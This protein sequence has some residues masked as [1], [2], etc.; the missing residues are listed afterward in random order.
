[1]ADKHNRHATRL[2]VLDQFKQ[3]P[4]FGQTEGTGRLIQDQHARAAVQ[5]PSDL[6]HLPNH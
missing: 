5:S 6:D 2:Q 3:T 1:M 4:G